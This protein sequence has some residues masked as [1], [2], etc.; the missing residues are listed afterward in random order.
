MKSV[1]L[2]LLASLVALAAGVAACIVVILLAV[3]VFG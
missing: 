3:D 1:Q 2:I